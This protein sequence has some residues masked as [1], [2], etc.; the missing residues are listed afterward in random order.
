MIKSA[1]FNPYLLPLLRGPKG[2]QIVEIFLETSNEILQREVIL[3]R[4]DPPKRKRE[5]IDHEYFSIKNIE[6]MVLKPPPIVYSKYQIVNSYPSEEESLTITSLKNLGV[7]ITEDFENTP[8]SSYSH[9][10]KT[11][12][13]N[14]YYDLLFDHKLKNFIAVP[15]YIRG[16]RGILR[17]MNKLN[18]GGTLSFI[19]CFQEEEIEK[20]IK[21]AAQI[22]LNFTYDRGSMVFLKVHPFFLSTQETKI[23]KEIKKE[24]WGI[25]SS[26]KIICAEA[27]RACITN[28]PVLI[29]GET[30]TGK[31]LLANMVAKYSLWN[32]LV[33]Y[34]EIKNHR[35]E[36]SDRGESKGRILD[37]DCIDSTHLIYDEYLKS[38]NTSAI[39]TS[40]FES[41]MF[42]ILDKTATNVHGRMGFL[43]RDTNEIAKKNN[44]TESNNTHTQTVFLDEIADLSLVNQAKLLQVIE[45]KKVKPI[46][47]NKEVDISCTRIL[48]STNRNIEDSSIFREDLKMRFPIKIEIPPLREREDDIA[49]IC[50]ESIKCLEKKY[51]L[52]I[53]C[54]NHFMDALQS[55]E[56]PGN[57]RELIQILE[58]CILMIKGGESKNICLKLEHLPKKILQ[59]NKSEDIERFPS[60]PIQIES[61]D[62]LISTQKE[63]K[64]ELSIEFLTALK[65][66]DLLKEHK[67]K[68]SPA[69]NKFVRQNP[70][71][72]WGRTRFN[73]YINN[74]LKEL[75]NDSEFQNYLI[76]NNYD[77]NELK[78]KL[79]V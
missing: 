31:N 61:L 54:D 19:K 3:F 52:K 60:Q 7:V 12:Y 14:Q 51:R 42:G 17:V 34:K 46:G 57:T 64:Y 25:S 73:S 2:F 21:T 15:V 32:N 18:W 48:A 62:E 79:F 24:W 68:K 74:E 1:A 55:Y 56:F 45:A 47:Q 72:N 41:E 49:Y 38:I 26:H 35:W 8:L 6:E 13:E 27:A 66:L 70:I 71:M 58:T 16:T 29:F 33:D 69:L 5:I 50:K 44:K 76:T 11:A 40:L 53:S 10:H 77:I 63:A 39:T 4:I 59:S 22:S 75:L 30:G 9:K 23:M 43:L 78:E 28:E 20:V 37:D 67:W 36:Y 65:I